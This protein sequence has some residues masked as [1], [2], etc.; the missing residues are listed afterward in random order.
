MK[1]WLIYIIITYFI[2][3]FIFTVDKYLLDKKLK[4]NLNYTIFLG[5]VYFLTIILIPFSDF[6]KISF[7]YIILGLFAGGL[8]CFSL[9][10][11][12][13]ALKCDDISVVVPLGSIK[14]ILV[15]I[16]SIIFLKES[17][18]NKEITAF[19]FFLIGGGILS[20]RKF[21][22]KEIK[23]TPALKYLA[24]CSILFAITSILIKYLLTNVPVFEG[25]IL[26]RVG[27]GIAG[28]SFLLNKK[29]RKSFKSDFSGLSIKIR[30]IFI[31][32]QTIGVATHY[33]LNLA[34]SLASISLINAALGLLHVFVFIL[35][36]L[37]TIFFPNIIKE[38]LDK[39]I[40]LKKIAG[41]IFII[42]ALYFLNI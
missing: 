28:I 40:I 22:L 8:F 18:N 23:V 3:A 32:N 11:H 31:L 24:L 1:P 7:I 20:I 41:M 35:A 30:G 21:S 5:M 37:C 15:L 17:L 19:V 4:N 16:L 13:K 38:N 42:S 34:I 9:I 12:F 27:T 29:V 6:S 26:L 2:L 36:L 33:L 25:F 10:F 39:R 14:S